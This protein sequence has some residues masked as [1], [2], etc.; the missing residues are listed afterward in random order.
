[1]EGTTTV[2]SILQ[3]LGDIFEA[4]IGWTVDVGT[5]V[6]SSPFLMVLIGIP[7]AL[8]AIGVFKRLINLS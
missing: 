5:T 2:S 6:V 3:T 1:M 4:V 7:V 8:V